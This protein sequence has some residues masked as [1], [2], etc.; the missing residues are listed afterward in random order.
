MKYSSAVSAQGRA[1]WT[2]RVTGGSDAIV[3][4]VVA[5]A[6]VYPASS[7]RAAANITLRPQ[8]IPLT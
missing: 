5:G 6:M 2:P 8:F 4:G 7:K 3:A 1:D